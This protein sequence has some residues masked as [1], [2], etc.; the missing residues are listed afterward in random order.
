MTTPFVAAATPVYGL[1][2]VAEGQPAHY[3]R[4]HLQHNAE[5]IEAALIAGGVAAPGATDLLALAGEVHQL[6]DYVYGA[7]PVDAISLLP[8]TTA[9]EAAAASGF[10]NGRF[11]HWPT[12]P[13][14]I[15][16]AIGADVYTAGGWRVVSHPSP[17]GPSAVVTKADPIRGGIKLVITFASGGQ[18][19]YLRQLVPEL[20]GFR[21]SRWTACFDVETSGGN[22]ETDVYVQSRLNSNDAD[23]VRA[24]DTAQVLL[25]PGRR[26]VACAIDVPDFDSAS[27]LTLAGA[28]ASSVVWAENNYL[29]S[30]IRFVAVAAGTI[31]VTVREATLVPGARAR[32]P[33]HLNPASEQVKVEAYHETGSFQANGLNT[34]SGQR[35][36]NVP[37][38]TRKHRSAFA[39]ANITLTDAAGNAGK[40]STYDIAGTRTD[41][42]AYT[43]IAG[44]GSP[45]SFQDGFAVIVGNT[46]TI[47]GAAFSYE[48]KLY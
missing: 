19:L 20:S 7:L 39:A 45:T 34:A 10:Y 44:F 2:Y 46:T 17:P 23:R 25:T 33:L 15:N 21:A 9:M 24:A 13:G 43:S 36:F 18:Y 14:P 29:E 37:F 41:N 40:I 32:G 30:A 27:V 5:T 16:V 12:G 31:T 4:Q 48:A 26:R 38:R 11:M 3:T 42:V 6:E 28:P 47:A 8:M 22:V 35:R 1:R